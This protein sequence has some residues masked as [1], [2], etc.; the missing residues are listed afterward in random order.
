MENPFEVSTLG[1]VFTPDW[2]VDKMLGL[3]KNFGTV[4]E[5]SAGTGAFM[6]KLEPE[7]VGLDID[8][9]FSSSRI[10]HADFFEHPT[11]HK[12]ET[13]IGNPPYVSHDNII[14][15]TKKLLSGHNL[16]GNANLYLHFIYKL[17][18]HLNPGG[19]LI[20]ITPRDFLK[21]TSAAKVNNRLYSQGSMTHYYELGD[22]LIFRHYAP[23]CA[24]WRWE[25]GSTNRRMETGQMFENVDGQILFGGVLD[26]R[27][28]DYFDVKVGA[29]SG[30]DNVFS[31]GVK[32]HKR[33]VCSTTRATGRLRAMLYDTYHPYLDNYKDVLMNR[34]VKEFNEDN[35]WEWGRKFYDKKGPRIYVNTHTRL[36]EPFFTHTAEA[37]DSSILAL[38]PKQNL[39]IRNAIEC[40][41]ETDW[42]TLGFVCDGRYLFTQRSLANAPF[43]LH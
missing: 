38:F 14:P 29:A 36:P 23:N 9:Y 28:R 35:W 33:F 2:V 4:L 43:V 30:A 37:Y 41:N 13:I 40:L 39:D 6:L 8:K 7:A 12:Y 32:G 25:K 20:F 42:E 18:D 21:A 17:I 27:V 22:K 31:V 16:P 5:P 34:R 24:I 3:R 26:T 11:Y 10:D 1:Q 19:E 15:E